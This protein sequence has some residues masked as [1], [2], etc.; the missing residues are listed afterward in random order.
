MKNKRK[1]WF[2]CYKGF[3]K[4]FKKPTNFKYVGD[5]ITSPSIIISNHVGTKAPLSFELYLDEK[6]R[7][8]GTHE[9]NSGLKN[10]YRYQTRVFYHE[11]RG[12]NL[13]LARLY[14]LLASPLTYIFYKGLNLIST[15]K[16]GRF[17]K[18][19]K[20]SFNA[21]NEGNSI[22]I[23]P[24]VS[25]KGYLDELEGLHN[26]FIMFADYA[27]RKGIDLPIVVTYYHKKS[28]VHIID[29]PLNYSQLLNK[30]KTY[31]EIAKALLKR[32]NELFKE[33]QFTYEESLKEISK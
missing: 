16:D 24:E 10:M 11:K 15:Y 7:F 3:I 8:W 20:E 18:T 28:N 29:N 27:Y 25:D 2:R 21:V 22:I 13:H 30:Y 33:L 32:C 31:D 14:C 26:G 23:F 6:I 1:F 9:M 12:W 4:L 5:K 17:I 19:I